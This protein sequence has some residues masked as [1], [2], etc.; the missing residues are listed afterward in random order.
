MADAN[1]IPRFLLVNTQSSGD[2]DIWMRHVT[3]HEE[4]VD[5]FALPT[6]G[7]I[8]GSSNSGNV[9]CGV[10][11]TAY[12]KSNRTFSIRADDADVLEFWLE[13][14]VPMDLVDALRNGDGTA[15]TAKPL[16][17]CGRIPGS[18]SIRRGN[19]L[20]GV[21]LQD[22]DADA[23]EIIIRADDAYAPA[24]WMEIR[25]PY[26]HLLDFLAYYEREFGDMPDLD[27]GDDDDDEDN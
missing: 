4:A 23:N 20:D 16:D 11:L 25:V 1:L 26:Q 3:V 15:A 22:Y 27:H 24:F 2:D 17:A 19:K 14:D 21:H 6:K 5:A 13:V 12:K 18:V 10:R 7:R 8:P 9:L